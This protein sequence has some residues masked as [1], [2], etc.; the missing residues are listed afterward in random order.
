MASDDERLVL[1]G[2]EELVAVADIPGFLAVGQRAFG[3]IGVGGLQRSANRVQ[4]DAVT[5]QLIGI[6]FHA[7]SWARAAPRK[8]LTHALHLRDFL[9]EDGIGGVVNLGRRNVV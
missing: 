1:E 9:S 2:F 6:C 4:S 8:N 3:E 5:I 7:N